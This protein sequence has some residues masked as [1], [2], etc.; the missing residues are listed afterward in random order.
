MR[1]DWICLVGR[2]RRISELNIYRLYKIVIY[3]SLNRCYTFDTGFGF[4]SQKE[5][6]LNIFQKQTFV[7]VQKRCRVLKSTKVFFQMLSYNV[8]CKRLKYDSF[9]TFVTTNFKWGLMALEIFHFKILTM[10]WY[11]SNHTCPS[12]L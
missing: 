11:I 8:K 9:K 6:N 1:M 5:L 10:D 7:L 4:T 3:V 12:P 2:M